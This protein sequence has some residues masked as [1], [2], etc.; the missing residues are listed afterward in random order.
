MHT[1]ISSNIYLYQNVM[2]SLC[3]YKPE[4]FFFAADWMFDIDFFY[5]N[6]MDFKP[7]EFEN[8]FWM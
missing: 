3:G 5:V 1:L 4:D 6:G 7:L 2:V 8:L